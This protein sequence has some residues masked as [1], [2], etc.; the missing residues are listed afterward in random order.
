MVV[1]FRDG[2]VHPLSAQ[3]FPVRLGAIDTGSNAI[4]FQVADFTGP[5][6]YQIISKI[7]LPIRLGHLV[8]TEG[9][10]DATTMDAAAGAFKLFRRGLTELKVSHF[11]AVAT[12]ATREAS[13]RDQFL[14][15]IRQASGIELRPISGVDEARYVHRAV[16]SRVDL[17]QGRWIL[18]DLGG[19]SVEVSLVDDTG[20]LWSQSYP[21]GTVRLLETMEQTGG[22]HESVRRWVEERVRH[23]TIP[24]PAAYPGPTSFAATGGNIEAIARLALSHSH[25]TRASKLPLDNLESVIRLLSTMNFEERIEHLDLR[26]DRADVILPAALVYQF[27]ATQSGADSIAVPNVGVKDGV[28]LEL[29]EEWANPGVSQLRSVS[30]AT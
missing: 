26:P 7:R 10:L 22:R 9:G 30:S 19:G 15:V 25:S 6:A 8:F 1:E 13:N 18:V 4:R 5:T 28:L 17:S 23:L 2:T 24:S 21:I 14:E 16:R 12:S 27:F 3:G 29:A 11:R 20:I